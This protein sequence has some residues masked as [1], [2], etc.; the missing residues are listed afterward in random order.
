MGAHSF[1]FALGL[2]SGFSISLGL[3]QHFVFVTAPRVVRRDLQSGE[4]IYGEVKLAVSGRILKLQADL[5]AC[6]LLLR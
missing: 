5:E 3:I 2:Y 1:K 4:I 6:S